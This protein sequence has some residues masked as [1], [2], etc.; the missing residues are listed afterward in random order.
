MKIAFYMPFKP[1]GHKNPSGDLII[2]TELHDFLVEKGCDVSIVSRFRLRWIYLRPLLWPLFIVEFFRVLFTLL[3][4]RPDAWFSYHS[5]Y[6]APDI[7]GYL[8]CRL[9]NIPYVIFQ[10][11]YS[12]K[13]K[14]KVKSWCGFH[15]NR[16]AL[17]R[18]D[19]VFTNKL[20]DKINLERLLD[21][22]N[23]V[24]V[25]P[26]IKPDEFEFDKDSRDKLR[27]RYSCQNR[28]VVLT[29]AMFR[30]GVK[31]QS[32]E[33]VIEVCGD[34]IHQGKPLFLMIAGDGVNHDYLLDKAGKHLG[35]EFAFLGKIK[36][37][38]MKEVYSSADIFVFPGIN[39]SLGMVY[40]EAQSCALPVVAYKNWGASQAVEHG[41]TGL[42]ADAVDDH[43]FLRQIAR[44]T[45]DDDYRR[46]LGQNGVQHVRE[47]HDITLNYGE[48]Y[49][50]LL[51]LLKSNN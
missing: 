31:T 19:L 12:T 35:N 42:L 22:E 9:L 43:G 14:R 50:H 21:K 24:Y 2:G 20:P 15:L 40:L 48:V 45:E 11:I 44:L 17:L 26:G 34:L 16:L 13:R 25:P 23:V 27:E 41:K 30:E 10:G 37:S 39:E 33:K 47:K 46:K 49:L 18:A 5:Y 51:S 38:R 7:L 36:R 8:C 3:K 32:L 1:L 28:V 4:N 29:A 6:K